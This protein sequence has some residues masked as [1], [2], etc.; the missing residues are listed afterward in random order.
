MYLPKR[1]G[2]YGVAKAHEQKKETEIKREVSL[3]LYFSDVLATFGRTLK[4][5]SPTATTN[6]SLMRS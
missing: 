5:E 4:V 3:L 6:A 2:N 1:K